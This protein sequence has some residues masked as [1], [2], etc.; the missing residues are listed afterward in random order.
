MSPTGTTVPSGAGPGPTAVLIAPGY[1]G[2]GGRKGDLVQVTTVDGFPVAGIDTFA[3]AGST[4]IHVDDITGWLGALGTIYDSPYRE[5]VLVSATTPDTAGM[6]EG[7]GTLTL[8]SATQFSHT[9]VISVPNTPDQRILISSMPSALIQAGFYI[10]THYG[11]I[12]GSTA[13]VMQS[14]RGQAAPSG[15]KAA[16]DWYSQAEKIIAR[17]ARV[18]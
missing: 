13:A 16:I 11:L 4:A 6:I 3:P 7:P 17:Y 10:A 12:R 2:S 9:P 1:V 8:T 5:N 18:F 14:A 15:T